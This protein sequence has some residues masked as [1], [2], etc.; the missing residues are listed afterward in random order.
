MEEGWSQIDRVRFHTEFKLPIDSE[1]P[2]ADMIANVKPHIFIRRYDIEEDFFI[3]ISIFFDGELNVLSNDKESAK[4][5]VSG[6]FLHF[7][8][9][10]YEED[11]FSVSEEGWI[12]DGTL[13]AMFIGMLM[14]AAGWDPLLQIPP[15]IQQ[16]L[17]EAGKALS[18]SNYRSCVVMCRRTIEALL[19][20]SF[21]RLLGTE[22]IDA[23]GRTLSLY[24]MIDRFKRQEP[25]TIPIHLLHLLDSI[26]LIGNVPGAHAEEIEGYHFT[27]ADAEYTLATVHYFLEQY[28]S[29]ID[30]EVTTYYTLTIDLSDI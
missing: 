23:Q 29:K 20:F 4:K 18:I 9:S 28:F 21:P 15:A 27:K 26:R 11:Q 5:Y 7:P 30:D 16:S 22:A 25:S 8:P 10:F 12:V 19:K 13:C 17:D 2:L 6:L 14:G 1:H 3:A 24:A